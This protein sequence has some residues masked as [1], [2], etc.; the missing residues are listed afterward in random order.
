MPSEVTAEDVNVDNVVNLVVEGEFSESSVLF[1]G[2][3]EVG[4][5]VSVVN[6]EASVTFVVPIE[7]SVEDA[8]VVSEASVLGLVTSSVEERGGFVDFEAS[9][10]IIDSVLLSSMLVDED[11]MSDVVYITFSVVFLIS[12]PVFASLD[13]E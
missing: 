1:V 4:V 7:F 12:F 2:Q 6:F 8:N 9:V 10:D 13:V 5:V 11:S 3:K